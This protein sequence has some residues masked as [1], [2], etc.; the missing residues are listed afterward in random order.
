M[1]EA[2]VELVRAIIAFF[3]LLIFTRL[4]GKQQ[5]SQLTFFDY[6]LGITVGS[7]AASMTTD[8][9]SMAWP[10]WVGLVTWIVCVL[11]LQVITMKWRYASKYID[12]EPTIVIMNGKIM[13]KAMKKM[14]YRI[15]D[16]TVQLREQGAFDIS[17]IEYAILETSGQLSVLKKSIYQPVTPKDLNIMSSYSGINTELIY[18]GV[19]IEQNLIQSKHDRA[20]LDNQLKALGIKNIS[21]VFFA[22]ID[23]NDNLYVDKYEDHL[24]DF[25][26]ISDYDGPY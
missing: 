21:E 9:T 11:I 7:I 5:L 26:D 19:L 1:N 22:T 3:T 23:T 6:V 8:L 4:L 14:R 17:Q 18:D 24:S 2:L 12:G 13:D 20:W 15:C 16:L 25:K 10:H